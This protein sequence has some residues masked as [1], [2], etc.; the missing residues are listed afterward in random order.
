MGTQI[1]INDQV[2]YPPDSDQIEAK[3]HWMELEQALRAA[4][5]AGGGAVPLLVTPSGDDIK[6]PSEVFQALRLVV[7]A[8]NRGL[9]VMVN[10]REAWV[11]TQQAASILGVSR[12]TLVRWLDEKRMPY[13]QPGRH[14]RIKLRDV[15]E[16]K[17]ARAAAQH[18]A[19]GEI[20]AEEMEEGLY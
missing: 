14:R 3:A 11:S 12:M 7:E 16:Y 13:E 2:L 8:I 6:L 19:L 17:A 18:H 20:A 10:P 4:D 15:L 9:P 1:K 5:Q